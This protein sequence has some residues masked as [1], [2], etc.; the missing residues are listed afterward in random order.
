MRRE[1]GSGSGVYMKFPCSEMRARERER[2]RVICPIRHGHGRDSIEG[3][4][5]GG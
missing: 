2:D 5:L 3:E 4:G 1:R